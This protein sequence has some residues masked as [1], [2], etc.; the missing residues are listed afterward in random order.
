MVK[1]TTVYAVRTKLGTRVSYRFRTLG[2]AKLAKQRIE[3]KG[4]QDL[5]VYK[6]TQDLPV[7][8]GRA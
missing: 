6:T 4:Y 7:Q 2:E 1:K 3:A 8:E 5:E